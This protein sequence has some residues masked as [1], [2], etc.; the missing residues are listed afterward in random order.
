MNEEVAKVFADQVSVN[1]LLQNLIYASGTAGALVVVCGLLLIDGATVRRENA[2]TSTIEK[3]IGFFIGVA[4]YYVIGF[5]IWASQYYVMEGGT[6]F[7]AI[8]DWWLAGSLTVQHAQNVDPATFPGLNNFQIFVFFLAVFAGIVNV[9]LHFSIGERIKASA[10]YVICAFA[11]IVSSILSNWTWGSVGLLSN[12]GFHDFFGV[13]FV[14]LCPAGIAMAVLPW[15]GTRPGVFEPHPKVSEY[16]YP[17]IG[18]CAGS[19]IMI[20]SGLVLVILSCL[21]FFEPGALAVSV[22]MADTSA[23]VALNN[24]CLGWTGGALSGALI[25]YST[26]KYSYLLLGPL[27]GYVSTASGLD[28][29]VPW[30]ALLV[31]LGGPV[32]AYIAYEALQKRQIDEHKLIPLFVGAGI[33]GLIVLGLIKAG[34]PRGGYHGISEGTYAF[35]HGQIGIVMQVVGSIVCVGVGYITG[36][37]LSF[38]LNSTIGLRNSDEDQAVGLDHMFWEL[39]VEKIERGPD[40]H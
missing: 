1:S 37:V 11:T 19:L 2:F 16:F 9:L 38:L 17:S 27:A 10:Y 25:A 28:V 40:H 20:F 12:A 23:G 34:V 6:T 18:L 24:F 4:V 32:M 5:A 39:T 30:Q 31:S 26:R 36:L 21:F 35:Q 13:G 8:K 7:D 29:Y 14:Y 33:Y 22:T 15:T 3:T